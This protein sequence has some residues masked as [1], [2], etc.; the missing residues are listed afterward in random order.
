MS[1]ASGGKAAAHDNRNPKSSTY[2]AKLR[3][4]LGEQ[5]FAAFERAES[6]HRNHLENMPLYIASVFAGLLAEAKIGQGELGL[7]SFVVGWMVTRVL[8]T[9]NYLNVESQGWSYI[10]SLLWFVNIG[11]AFAIL[12]RSAYALGN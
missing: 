7:K 11:W 2:L 1:I 6:C 3:Q 10:R 4:R 9:I 8:Y 12:G 5:K